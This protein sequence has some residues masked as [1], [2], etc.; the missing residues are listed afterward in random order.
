MSWRDHAHRRPGLPFLGVLAIA[1]GVVVTGCQP[2]SNSVEGSASRTTTATST[3]PVSTASR[4]TS[5]AATGSAS[6]GAGAQSAAKTT[7]AAAAATTTAPAGAGIVVAGSALTGSAPAPGACHARAAADGRPLPDPRCTPGAIDAAVSQADIAS[8]ICRSGYTT[9]VRPP[10]SVTGPFKLLDEDAYGVHSGELD[11]L[12]P[13]ELGGSSDA[14][15][16]WVE[17]GSIPNPKDTVEND[18][19]AAV[20]R[21]QV[22]LAAAQRLIATDWTTALAAIGQAP[23]A[24]APTAEKPAPT[25]PQPAPTG[26]AKTAALTCAASVSNASPAQNSTTS[27]LVTTAAGASLTVTAH[28]KSKDTTHSATADGAGHASVPF[29]ISR[30][31]IGYTVVVDVSVSANGHTGSCSTAFTPR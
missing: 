24:A 4:A 22:L 27:V 1:A 10:T 18:L 3:T 30:A 13:L 11:H 23:P 26:T 8:T 28:Y 31:S 7:I 21:G 12:I 5:R 20:C 16:L 19:H 6:A 9:T 14:R 2:G 29:D 15:N 17:P 25:T